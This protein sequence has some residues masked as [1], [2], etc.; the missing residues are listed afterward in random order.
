MFC[1]ELKSKFNINFL[2]NDPLKSC[3][4][5]WFIGTRLDEDNSIEGLLTLTEAAIP[6]PYI[7]FPSIRSIKAILIESLPSL[8][9]V[10]I[11]TFE[12]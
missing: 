8:R 9:S 5:A 4:S 3:F 11:I 7:R 12:E 6:I 1:F 2:Y 10:E